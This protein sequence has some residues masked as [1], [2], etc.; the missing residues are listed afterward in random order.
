MNITVSPI[1]NIGLDT[2]TESRSEESAL[3]TWVMLEYSFQGPMIS[4]LA[5]AWKKPRMN[6]MTGKALRKRMNITRFP[7]NEYR[8]I[9]VKMKDKF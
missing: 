3:N 8:R 5:S 9:Y 4:A 2:R 7:G 1:P 6:N